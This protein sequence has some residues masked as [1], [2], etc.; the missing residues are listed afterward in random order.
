MPSAREREREHESTHPVGIQA[1][2]LFSHNSKQEAKKEVLNTQ[3]LTMSRPR[4]RDAKKGRRRTRKDASSSLTRKDLNVDEEER[5]G[6]SLDV[7]VEASAS[8]KWSA[9]QGRNAVLPFKHPDN[10][11]NVERDGDEHGSGSSSSG[12]ARASAADSGHGRPLSSSSASSPPSSGPAPPNPRPGP[13]QRPHEKHVK[14]A[15]EQLK[16]FVVQFPQAAS[17]SDR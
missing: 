16:S 12:T 5:I 15:L 6:A 7:I 8:L 13:D 14:T 4:P 1:Y 2:T 11:E 10:D 9:E 3:S 17:H